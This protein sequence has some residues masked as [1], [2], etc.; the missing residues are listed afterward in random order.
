MFTKVLILSTSVGAGHVRAGEALERAFLEL[1][2]AR[3][4]L[5]VDTLEY[6]TKLYS[7]LYERAN[8][9]MVHRMPAVAG[10]LYDALDK[11]WQNERQRV[12][13]D[14]LNTRPLTRMLQD[15]KK[16]D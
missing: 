2:A 7:S 14:R 4:V 11:P 12:A 3:E 8:S 15:G 5:H 6:A 9:Y 16:R 1:G 13:F 10:W